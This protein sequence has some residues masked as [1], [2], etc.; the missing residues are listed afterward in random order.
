[1]RSP[2]YRNLDRPF[3]IAG[4]LP[5]EVIAL[6]ILFVAGGEFAQFFGISRSWSFAITLFAGLAMFF[7][8][9]Y[10]GELFIQRL[11]RFLSLP[12]Y[13]HPRLFREDKA[14]FS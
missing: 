4:F 10:F 6:A 7:T 3:Q 5:A 9:K 8:H 1:M 13:I 12:S 14:K 2:V 11:A